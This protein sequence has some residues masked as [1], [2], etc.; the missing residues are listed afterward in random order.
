[1]RSANTV[2]PNVNIGKDG[3]MKERVRGDGGSGGSSHFL[4][5]A[6]TSFSGDTFS[7][8]RCRACPRCAEHLKME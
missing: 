7:L 1:M 8:G 4:P 5:S 2:V 3:W 6:K